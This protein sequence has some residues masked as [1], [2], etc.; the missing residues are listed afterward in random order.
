MQSYLATPDKRKLDVAIRWC[1]FLRS[2]SLAS[3]ED[4]ISSPTMA[5]WTPWNTSSL[6]LSLPATRGLVRTLETSC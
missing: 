6:C 4:Q 3:A 1:T 2:F 5:G